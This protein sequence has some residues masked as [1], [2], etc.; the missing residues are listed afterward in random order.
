ML[1]CE[2]GQSRAVFTSRYRLLYAPRIKPISKGGTTDPRHNYQANKHHAS[3]WRPLQ[4][5]DLAADASEQRNLVAPAER[6]ALNLS[7]A[8]QRHLRG[9]LTWLQGAL[10]G[11]MDAGEAAK[12]CAPSAR[13]AAP[14][15][16]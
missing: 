2:V 5:Y 15:G 7:A 1:F 6:A 14:G 16:V 12:E 10:R 13:A 3:Y 11:H 9:N 8:E 4:L